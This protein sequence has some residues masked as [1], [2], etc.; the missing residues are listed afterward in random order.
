MKKTI[1]LYSFLI[2]AVALFFGYCGDDEP[3]P[4]DGDKT[5]TA[6][7]TAEAA[8][9]AP[10]VIDFDTKKLTVKEGEPVSADKKEVKVKAGTD[11]TI[12]VTKKKGYFGETAEQKKK[13]DSYAW[14]AE[15]GKTLNFGKSKSK[16]KKGKGKFN[17]QL[18][19]SL[20]A[21]M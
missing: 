5:T 18:N 19:S 6:E 14:K 15:A 13:G 3:K 12:N 17:I 7:E 9:P 11:V 20:I 21:T 2:L 8:A 10:V 16:V 4:E 1:F